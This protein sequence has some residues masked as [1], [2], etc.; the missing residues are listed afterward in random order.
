MLMPGFPK[1]SQPGLQHAMSSIALI[2]QVYLAE[3]PVFLHA[4]KHLSAP[5]QQ[6]TEQAPFRAGWNTEA[7]FEKKIPTRRP[8][9][10][11]SL[12]TALVFR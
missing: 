1:L 6:R 10:M 5:D 3:K 4:L 2:A 12:S 9:R 7:S 8:R 11:T